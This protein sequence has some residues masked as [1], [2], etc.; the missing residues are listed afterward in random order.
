MSLSYSF[1]SG[2]W[3][4]RKGSCGTSLGAVDVEPCLTFFLG[5]MM[6]GDSND[7]TYRRRIKNSMMQGSD[8]KYRIIA[9]NSTNNSLKRNSCNS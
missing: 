6:F 1:L 7:T 3:R 5:D 4:G 2:G 8:E 9:S